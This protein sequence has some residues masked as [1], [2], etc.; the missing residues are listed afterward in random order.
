MQFSGQL[1]ISTHI[2][3]IY[4]YVY[5]LFLCILLLEIK[6]LSATSFFFFKCQS[7]ISSKGLAGLTERLMTVSE[8]HA[9]ARELKLVLLSDHSYVT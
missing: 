1:N 5:V 6:A 8:V 3:I 7:Y 9:V 4:I 2:Y